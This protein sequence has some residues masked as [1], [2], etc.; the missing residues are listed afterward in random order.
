MIEEEV[1]KLIN[2]IIAQPASRGALPTLAAAVFLDI[3][4][5]SF[6][7]PD[8]FLEM[9]GGP[10]LARVSALANNQDLAQNLWHVSEELTR[11]SWT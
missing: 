8:G 6:I 7:G 3:I 4:G 1:I 5:G 2:K 10:K 11:V 9:R